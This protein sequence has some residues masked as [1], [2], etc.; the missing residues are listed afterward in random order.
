MQVTLLSSQT[1]GANNEAK[2]PKG[3]GQVEVS[4]RFA[5][6]VGLRFVHGAL[7]LRFDS[8]GPFSFTSDVIWPPGDNYDLAVRD[9]VQTVVQELQGHL[10]STSVKLKS[11]EWDDVASSERGF[12]QAARAATEAAFKVGSE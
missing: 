4:F 9:E 5:R 10:E 6:C 3:P 8:S 12:R 11:I 2:Y 7:T 1:W